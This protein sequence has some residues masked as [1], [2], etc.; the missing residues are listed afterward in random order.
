MSEPIQ[1][2]ASSTDLSYDD[3]VAQFMAPNRPVVLP[4]S[5]IRHWRARHEWTTDAGATTGS[6]AVVVRNIDI[7]R[8]EALFGQA[9]AP[10]SDCDVT[11]TYGMAGLVGTGRS[12]DGQPLLKE[13]TIA[14]YCDYL[15]RRRQHVQRQS[16]S[17]GTSVESRDGSIG[18]PGKPGDHDGTIVSDP[19]P[20]DRCI[21]LKDWHMTR[22]F[23][24]YNAYELPVYFSDDWL[25]GYWDECGSLDQNRRDDFRF[26]YIGPAG[27]WT[28]V[29]F[30][31][32][33]SFSWSANICGRK[34]WIFFPPEAREMLTD[35]AGELLSDVR[36]VDETRFPNFRNAPR[37]ELFQEEGQLVFVPSQW[38]HQ[39]INLTDVISINH[40]W[41]NGC[42]ILGM[43]QLA[44]EDAQLVATDLSLESASLDEISTSK[45]HGAVAAVRSPAAPAA[46]FG[47]MAATAEQAM[48]VQDLL[49][50]NG[51]LDFRAMHDL[52]MVQVRKIQ[53]R[54]HQLALLAPSAVTAEVCAARNR[55][56]SDLKTIR[57]ILTDISRSTFYRECRDAWPA[58]IDIEQELSEQET[59]QRRLTELFESFK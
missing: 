25:N 52:C 16:R 39:V 17:T 4:E 18:K 59:L 11:Q 19:L 45:Q 41:A 29:H 33:S 42:N 48:T 58:S 1:L 55:H 3:F 40:N 20:A 10:I 32:M 13:V 6:D 23:P 51:S 27:S 38:Y 2:L 26:C 35:A 30:D 12:D 36:S 15:R 56:V 47:L 34:K 54:S 7:D 50:A 24:G 28:P 44:K 9:V 21:Y 46:M 22:D 5:A 31:V 37:I 43:W 49:R 14:K 8:I 57:Q 53:Q